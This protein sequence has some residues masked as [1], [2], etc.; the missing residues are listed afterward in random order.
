MKEET[1]EVDLRPA[2]SSRVCVL[3]CGPGAELRNP[4]GEGKDGQRYAVSAIPVWVCEGC[5]HSAV[6]RAGLA[7]VDERGRR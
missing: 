5:A 3:C 2:M 6:L 1:K 7:Y 4:Q